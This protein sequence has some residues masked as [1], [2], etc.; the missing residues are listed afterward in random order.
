MEKA[1]QRQQKSTGRNKTPK[2]RSVVRKTMNDL[3]WGLPQGNKNSRI[4]CAGSY[5]GAA[6]WL[7]Q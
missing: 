6:Y 7:C 3:S 2:E 5:F 1:K 4:F